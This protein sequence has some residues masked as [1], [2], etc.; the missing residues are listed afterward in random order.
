MEI[1]IRLE[2]IYNNN[3][4]IESDDFIQDFD[5]SFSIIGNKKIYFQ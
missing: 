5:G 4:S 1:S 2:Y 3:I